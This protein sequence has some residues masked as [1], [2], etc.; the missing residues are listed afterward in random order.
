M[1]KIIVGI[2]GA[3][4]VIY[5]IRLL[6]VLKQL[7]VETHLI[8][9]GPG[10]KNIEIETEFTVEYVKNLA[11]EVYDPTDITAAVA[12]GSFKTDGMVI[13]P[14]TMR[15]LS[16]IANSFDSNLLVRAADC[17]LKERRKLVVVAR[18]T[19]LHIGHIRLLAQVCEMG[20]I[21]VPPIP[22]FYHKPKTIDDLIYH[23]V[24]KILD[25]LDIEVEEDL[26][27]RWAGC[28]SE[29]M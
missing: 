14:C 22:A 2:S 1:K 19:P 20:G 21:I 29:T 11:T 26:F 4:G 8:I 9:T 28:P 10:E 17:I 18:E 27:Q 25:Q 16:A 24:G 7:P 15:T 3:T 13:V 6:E 12:S 5:G 23:L